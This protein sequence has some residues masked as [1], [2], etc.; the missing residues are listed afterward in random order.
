MGK[1]K[2]LSLNVVCSF[3]IWSNSNSNIEA[4][5]LVLN[6]K[7]VCIYVHLEAAENEIE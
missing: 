5:A 6:V 3:N 7:F 2:E 1:E 4:G